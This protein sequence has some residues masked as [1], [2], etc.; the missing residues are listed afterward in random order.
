MSKSFKEQLAI[1]RRD[2]ILDA[3]TMVFVTKGFHAT[4]IKDIAR[5]ADIADGTIYNYFKNK[6]AL[7]IGILE[8]L[9]QQTAPDPN[10][11]PILLDADFETF[12]LTFLKMPLQTFADDEFKLIRIVLSEVMVNDELREHYYKTVIEPTKQ[13]GKTYLQQWADAHDANL[14]VDLIVNTL[15]S[16]VMGFTVQNILGDT[17]IRTQWHMLP[18]KITQL[19]VESLDLSEQED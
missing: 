10:Q 5:E 7:L 8:K 13:I 14:D 17:Y 18:N 3:A 4:S 1:A 12:V 11:M 19:L 15:S 6:H 16:I 2:Q 9:T